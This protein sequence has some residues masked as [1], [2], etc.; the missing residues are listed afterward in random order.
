MRG[1]NLCVRINLSPLYAKDCIPVN[2]YHIDLQKTAK[3][4]PHL[5]AIAEKMPPLLNCEVRLLIGYNCPRTLT[6]RQVIAGKDNEPYA[7]LTDLGWS[8]IGCSS[9]CLNETGSSLCHRVTVKELPI[10]TPMD[11]ISALE[12]DFKDTKGD[13]KTVSQED[14]IFLNK[15]KEGIRKNDQGHYE[16]PL[17]FKQRPHLPD[18]KK[19]AEIRLNHLQRRFYRDERYKDYT[20]Y[21]KEII[22]RGDIEVN[23]D[24]TPG[25]RWYMPHH[26]IYHPIKK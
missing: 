8:I 15:L 24:G 11:V 22:E 25:E 5:A 6:P 2:R 16:M 18:N 10:I 4:W 23:K 9:P 13:D 20:T 19:L 1:Y 17:P 3:Q 21:M 14:L 7:I 26:G 12:S